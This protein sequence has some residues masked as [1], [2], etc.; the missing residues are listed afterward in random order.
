MR[1][2]ILLTLVSGAAAL[3]L[4]ACGPGSGSGG[5]SPPPGPSGGDPTARLAAEGDIIDL[6]TVQF[7]MIAGSNGSVNI[8]ISQTPLTTIRDVPY[9]NVAGDG[10]VAQIRGMLRDGRKLATDAN[11]VAVSYDNNILEYDGPVMV[12]ND[13]GEPTG[14]N[15]IIS[16]DVWC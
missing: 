1:A 4:A 14:Q 10:G 7:C 8:M 2:F 5:A 13:E 16:V 9:I 12:V 6:E 11:G 15:V 3:G